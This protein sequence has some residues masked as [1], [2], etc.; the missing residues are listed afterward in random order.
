MS[1]E[2]PTWA[3]LRARIHA[4]GYETATGTMRWADQDGE[5]FYGSQPLEGSCTFIHQATG[6]RWRV[7]DEQGVLHV[8]DGHEAYVRNADGAMVHLRELSPLVPDGHPWSLFGNPLDRQSGL[9]TTPTDF[10][11]PT[12]PAQPVEVIGRRAWEVTLR[13]PPHKENPLVVTVDE[14]TGIVLRKVAGG[15]AWVAELTEFRPHARIDP[16]QFRW[17]GAYVESP[18][19]MTPTGR[20]LVAGMFPP[21][22][23]LTPEELGRHRARLAVNEALVA[24][25]D[26]RHEVL[27]AIADAEDPDAAQV[28]VARLL[29]LAPEEAQAILDMQLRWLTR[30]QGHKLRE[31]L[32]E[33]RQGLSDLPPDNAG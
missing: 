21:G 33:F 12:G 11:H 2:V 1:E 19:R 30:T 25:L 23:Q 10:Y 15:G 31:E 13:P 3:H 18:Q 6:E 28:A 22:A 8:Q 20:A 27:E 29:A 32:A 26:R 4:T 9:F 5:D 7:E 14:L 24:A 16:A 17:S